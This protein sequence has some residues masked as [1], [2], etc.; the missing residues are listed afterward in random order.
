MQ[1]DNNKRFTRIF[2][3]TLSILLNGFLPVTT[4]VG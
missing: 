4:Q 3:G 1:T 2:Y